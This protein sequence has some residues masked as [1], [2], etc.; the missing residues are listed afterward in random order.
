MGDAKSAVTFYE[1]S[2]EFLS[3]LPPTDIELVHTLSVSLNKVGDLKYYDGDL[4]SARNYYAKALDIRRNA[5]KENSK[6][7]SQV[8]NLF[9]MNVSVHFPHK[10]TSLF[11]SIKPI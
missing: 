8:S 6:L 11:F 9:H 10:Q 2:V 1:E 4:Q 7:S 3:K 5:V